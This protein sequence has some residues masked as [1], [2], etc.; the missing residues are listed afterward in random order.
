MNDA[1]DPTAA[2]A[3]PAGADLAQ[4]RTQAK[5]LRR[6]VH[7]GIGDALALLRRHHPRGARLTADPAARAEVTLRD[8]QLALARRYGFDGWH[9]LIQALGER[10]VAERDLHRWFGVEFNNEVWDLLDAGVDETS[11]RAD[12]DLVLYGAYAAARHWSECGGPAQAARAEHLIARA[13]LAVGESGTGLAHARRCLELVRAHQQAMA[14]WDEPFAQ[15]ALARALA[16]TGDRSAALEHLAAARAL[17]ASVA[18]PQDREVLEGQLA[19][20][21]WFG[22]DTATAA[23]AGLSGPGRGAGS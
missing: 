14:D 16:A 2:R 5:E 6:G 17:T 11:P 20:G 21:P 10:Q 18:D 13:A 15:E 7:R 12:R 22:L 3:L 9:G 23:G 4:V 8:A 19:R 1:A